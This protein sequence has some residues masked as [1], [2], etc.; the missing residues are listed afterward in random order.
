MLDASK[1]EL[2]GIEVESF[3]KKLANLYDYSRSLMEFEWKSERMPAAW[4]TRQALRP[5]TVIEDSRCAI[6]YAQSVH[7]WGFN[8]TSIRKSVLNHDGFELCLFKLIR[9]WQ[10][11]DDVLVKESTK[12]TLRALL[13]IPGV[14]LATA[15][16]WICFLDQKRYAIYDS[17]VSYALQN[18]IFDGTGRAFPYIGSRV[19]NG[20]RRDI[21]NGDACVNNPDRAVITYLNYLA[22]IHRT[23]QLLTSV[24]KKHDWSA[25]LVECCLFVEGK[26]RS[27]KLVKRS[28]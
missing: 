27:K 18:L 11:S 13:G 15:T 14:G 2:S 21:V 10:Q 4:E 26:S 23:A 9:E 16:K 20:R 24:E 19:S 3:A 7:R 25:S 8:N 22:V 28:V 17:R 5:C 6:E 12:T 1:R